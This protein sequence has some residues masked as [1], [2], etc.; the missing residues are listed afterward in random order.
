MLVTTTYLE[1]TSP[2]Q[3]RV[4]AEPAE[5]LIFARAEDP[6]PEFTRFLY[7]A[8]G[9]PW[10]WTDKLGFTWNDWYA[11]VTR[12]GFET[13]VAHRR[14]TPAGYVELMGRPT[15]EGTEVEIESFGL[16]PHAVGRRFGGHLLTRA[17][18]E[19]WR[20]DDRWPDLPPVRRVWLHTC[21]LDSAHARANYERRGLVAYDTRT[22]EQEVADPPGPWPDSGAPRPPVAAVHEDQAGTAA[23]TRDH[24]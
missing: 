19:A 9:G 14:G 24:T 18:T 17:L 7:T 5:S 3:L 4:A 2:D 23:S 10:H 13:W 15:D 16:L 21:T 11:H 22:H 12:D 6:S 8:V 20:L 1:Q